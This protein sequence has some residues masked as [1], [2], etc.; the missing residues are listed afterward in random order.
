MLIFVLKDCY[1]RTGFGS[2]KKT[3]E[4]YLDIN[5]RLFLDSKIHFLKLVK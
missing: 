3:V 4:L 1:L 5:E 2:D